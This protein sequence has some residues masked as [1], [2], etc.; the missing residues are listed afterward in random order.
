MFTFSLI[1]F[2]IV[3]LLLLTTFAGIG[4]G[5]NKKKFCLFCGRKIGSVKQCPYCGENV[6]SK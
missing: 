5:P 3:G 2:A 6:D 1:V 4:A